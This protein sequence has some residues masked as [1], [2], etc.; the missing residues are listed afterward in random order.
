MKTTTNEIEIKEI[1]LGQ[2]AIVEELRDENVHPE[3]R[4]ERTNLPASSDLIKS[5]DTNGFFGAIVVL[6]TAN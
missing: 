6:Q 5:I 1:P 4:D 3:L 2:I